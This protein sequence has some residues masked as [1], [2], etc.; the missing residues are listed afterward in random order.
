MISIASW[1]G[2]AADAIIATVSTVTNEAAVLHRE[3]G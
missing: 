1:V 3:P 2:T